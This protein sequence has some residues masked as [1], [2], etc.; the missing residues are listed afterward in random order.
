M[1]G[2]LRTNLRSGGWE[3]DI[4]EGF[5]KLP[6]AFICYG[7]QADVFRGKAIFKKGRGCDF[8]ERES[9]WF[10]KVEE[11]DFFG[12]VFWISGVQISVQIS[13]KFHSLR[14]LSGMHNNLIAC[15]GYTLGK[16]YFSEICTPKIGKSI[17]FG[18]LHT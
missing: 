11:F 15:L 5:T 2:M 4:L 3:K 6:T 18:N 8:F 13:E 10:R 7:R 9:V 12:F 14:H 1:D 16:V 17:F